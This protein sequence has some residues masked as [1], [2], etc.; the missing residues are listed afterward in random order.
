MEQELKNIKSE[1][2]E[3]KRALNCIALASLIQAHIQLSA[4]QQPAVTQF[5]QEHEN[6]LDA[7]AARIREMVGKT[8]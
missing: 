3:M 1:L 6:Q 4:K 2:G 7:L 8:M 5:A